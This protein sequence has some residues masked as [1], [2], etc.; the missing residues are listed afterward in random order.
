MAAGVSNGNNNNVQ[1]VPIVNALL[2]ITAALYRNSSHDKMII[3][4]TS[5]FDLT[6]SK[7]AKKTLCN[8]V[9]KRVHK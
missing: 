1:I 4:L 9:N 6:E 8:E 7:D 5:H 2:T 3:L